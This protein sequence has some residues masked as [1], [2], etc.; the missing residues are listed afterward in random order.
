[1]YGLGQ[2]YLTVVTKSGALVMRSLDYLEKRMI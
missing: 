2:M 1:M